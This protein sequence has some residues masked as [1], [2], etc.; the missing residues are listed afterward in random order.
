MEDGVK[1]I[2]KTLL[3]VPIIIYVSFAILNAFAFCFA[4]FKMLG[5]SYVL[6]QAVV[7]NNYL[8]ENNFKSIKTYIESVDNKSAFIVDAHM[9]IDDSNTRAPETYSEVGSLNK[10]QYGKEAT[11]GIAYQ[12]NLVWPFDYRRAQYAE[13]NTLGGYDTDDMRANMAS[14][15]SR[16]V[17]NNADATWYD[18]TA[19]DKSSANRNFTGNMVLSKNEIV[20]KYTVPGLRYYPDLSNS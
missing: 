12:F 9:I 13:G 20:I 2:F 4:Y 8:D 14:R 7:E 19:P 18:D 17:G 6:Q 1:Y 15:V 10:V 11:I 3:R 16:G 5:V